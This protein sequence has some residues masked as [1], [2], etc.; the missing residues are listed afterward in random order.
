MFNFLKKEQIKNN[1]GFSLIEIIIGSSVMLI[2]WITVFYTFSAL[3][4]FSLKDVSFVKASMLL[5][6]G[7]EALRSMR[8]RSWTSNIVPLSICMST[9]PCRLNYNENLNLWEATTSLVMIDGRFDRIFFISDVGRDST[10]NVVS[11]GGIFDPNSKKATII[12]SWY[13]GN[14]TT[15]Q[16]VETYLFNDFK[17]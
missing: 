10:F 4:Q 6:E 3:S 5:D 11:S 15:S 1:S 16:S 13:K 2:V 7:A 12:V 8:D 14:A 9:S 17:N